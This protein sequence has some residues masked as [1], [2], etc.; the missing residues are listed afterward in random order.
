MSQTISL[1]ISHHKDCR[2]ICSKENDDDP[3]GS[4]IV[5]ASLPVA[6]TNTSEP[7]ACEECTNPSSIPD[8]CEVDVLIDIM[9]MAVLGTHELL[10]QWTRAAFHDAGTFNQV[11]GEGGANGCLLNHPPMRYVTSY[12]ISKYNI[13]PLVS[14]LVAYLYFSVL[15]PRIASLTCH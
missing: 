10:P 14:S 3:F 11:T 6:L 9:E 8:K 1:L 5:D 13:P 12:P 15:S 2:R 4:C 7:T